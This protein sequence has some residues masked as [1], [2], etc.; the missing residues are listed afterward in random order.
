MPAKYQKFGL[1]RDKNLSDLEN[2]TQALGNLIDNLGN[3]TFLPSD[4][5]SA[6][7]GLRNTTLTAEDIQR[8]FGSVRTFTD[9]FGNETPF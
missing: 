3:E 4:L 6:V 2:P 7:E 1:R 9:N 8:T 5:T